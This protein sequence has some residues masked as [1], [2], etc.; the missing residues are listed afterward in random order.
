MDSLS[1]QAQ[2][3]VQAKL[4]AASASVKAQVQA[5]TGV[6][7]NSQRVQQGATSAL[8][9]LQHGYNPASDAD[10]AQLVHAIAGGCALIPGGQ[11][12]GAYVELL[13]QVGNQVACPLENAFASIGMGSPSPAC[14]GAACTHTGPP[15][16]AASVIAGSA[17]PANWNSQGSFSSLAVGA[18]ATYAAQNMNCKGG[19][20]PGMVV[21]AVVAMWN[22]THQSTAT[23][24]V[25]IP[26]LA[27]Y[28]A[29]SS[30]VLIP[31]WQSVSNA[32]TGNVDPYVYYAFQP[33]AVV[34][35]S[36][37]YSVP[38]QEGDWNS[39]GMPA[40]AGTLFGSTPPRVVRINAGMLIDPATGAAPKNTTVAGHA[41]AILGGG[42]IGG[43]MLAIATG[44]SANVVFDGAW[45]ILQTWAKDALGAVEGGIKVSTGAAE[46]L[47]RKRRRHA[48]SRR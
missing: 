48:A 39:P 11:I 17:L 41:G 5:T 8:S 18:L 10:S 7:L 46:G 32:T 19:V 45:N 36:S 34:N 29:G 20:P 12:F 21:D 27:I 2:A 24:L 28:G 43:M 44:R 23:V 40:V 37:I 1:A 16:T 6:D 22:Q 38:M 25:L 31:F 14:G 4:D 35:A 3:Q 13:W 9:L 47:G 33:V 42:F 26:P 15:A 30:P